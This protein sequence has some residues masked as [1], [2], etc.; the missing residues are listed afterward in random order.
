MRDG[1]TS[2]LIQNWNWNQN[3]AAGMPAYDSKGNRYANFDSSDGLNV[4]SECSMRD[5]KTLESNL[6][7]CMKNGTHIQGKVLE[8][9]LKSYRQRR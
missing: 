5:S 7:E 2:G 9:Y 8:N 4:G 3:S 1:L 6:H